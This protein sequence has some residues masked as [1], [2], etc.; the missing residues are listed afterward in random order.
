M[1][2]QLHRLVRGSG[3]SFAC[4]VL[5]MPSLALAQASAPPPP[6]AQESAITRIERAMTEAL[7]RGLDRIDQALDATLPYDM[8]EVL[9]NGDILIRRS[10]PAPVSPQPAPD[11]AA[12]PA[13]K[14]DPTKI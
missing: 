11:P 12:P 4:A 5:A 14:S 9:P 7:H 1:L 2:R 6:A 8:P 3:L 13:Q 10:K